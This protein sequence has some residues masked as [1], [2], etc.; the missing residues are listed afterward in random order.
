MHVCEILP[1]QQ[2]YHQFMPFRSI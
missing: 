2:P 1:L